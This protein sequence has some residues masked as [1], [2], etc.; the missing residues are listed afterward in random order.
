MSSETPEQPAPPEPVD[1]TGRGGDAPSLP[2]TVPVLLRALASYL[3]VTGEADRFADH[4]LNVI[5]DR[6]AQDDHTGGNDPI[7]R[8]G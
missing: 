3:E 7:E 8:I 4:L 6:D 1:A 5:R 2:V